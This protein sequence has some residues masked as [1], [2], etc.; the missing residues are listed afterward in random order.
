MWCLSFFTASLVTDFLALLSHDFSKSSERK[1]KKQ[2]EGKGKGRVGEQEEKLSNYEFA[3]LEAKG[4]LSGTRMHQE[5][6][7]PSCINR[8]AQ[9]PHSKE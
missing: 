2:G 1:K 8:A 4:K 6:S 3:L 5:K 9:A 7:S